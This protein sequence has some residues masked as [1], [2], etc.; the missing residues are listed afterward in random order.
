MYTILSCPNCASLP[1]ASPG[2]TGGE[3]IPPWMKL[4]RSKTLSKLQFS[5]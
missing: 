4:R 1:V 2:F 3:R 5:M